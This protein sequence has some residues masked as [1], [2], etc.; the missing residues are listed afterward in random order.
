MCATRIQRLM[1]S[2]VLSLVILLYLIGYTTIALWLQIFVI[3]MMVI[4]AITNFCPSIWILKKLF[5]PC[6]WDN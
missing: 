5:P 6:D 1:T 3:I 4:W 2:F